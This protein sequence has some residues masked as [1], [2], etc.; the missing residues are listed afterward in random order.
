MKEWRRCWGI[1]VRRA[2]VVVCMPGTDE[3]TRP[4]CGGR[5]GRFTQDRFG[6]G[7]GG[8]NRG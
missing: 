8:S 6:C 3:M 1:D 7:F 2:T 4:R 5:M